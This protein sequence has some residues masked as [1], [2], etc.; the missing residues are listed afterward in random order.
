MLGDFV[1]REFG[2]GQIYTYILLVMVLGFI[3][4]GCVGSGGGGSETESSVEEDV[5]E[6]EYIR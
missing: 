3:L 4:S 1:R 2:R 5:V 6:V